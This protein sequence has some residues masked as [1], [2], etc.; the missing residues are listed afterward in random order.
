MQFNIQINLQKGFVYLF[1]CLFVCFTSNFSLLH[2]ISVSESV[3]KHLQPRFIPQYG[4]AHP[5]CTR[6]HAQ[7]V[8]LVLS[9]RGLPERLMITLI[10]NCNFC[11]CLVVNLSNSCLFCKTKRRSFWLRLYFPLRS[12]SFV[13]TYFTVKRGLTVIPQ[14]QSYWMIFPSGCQEY[15]LIIIG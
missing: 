11:F 4:I 8:R 13:S 3:L 10:H 15:R 14:R 1:V 7:L 2:T 9:G 5:Y 12:N 6:F